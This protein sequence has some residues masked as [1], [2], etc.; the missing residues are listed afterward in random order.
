MIIIRNGDLVMPDGVRQLELAVDKGKIVSIAPAIPVGDADEVIDAKGCYVFPGFID[1]HT[2]FAM[3]NALAVTADDFVSGT[4]AA[5][6]GGT[7]TIINFA[8]PSADG[9]LLEGFQE[10][11]DKAKGHSSCNYKFHMELLRFDDKV[12]AEMKQLKELGVTSYK[13]YMAYAFR[14]WDGELYEAVKAA[15]ELGSLIGAHCEN[16]DLIDARIKELKAAGQLEVENHPLS[17]PA[18]I[19]AEAI[20]RFTSIGRLAG[21]PVH[22]VHVSSAEGLREIELAR[23]RGTAVTCETCPQY[24]LLNEELY[25]LPNFEGAKYVM[26]P[27]LRTKA[28]Q[29][30]LQ[31]AVCKGEFQT[32]AT[33]HCS[34]TW[35]T[36]K[37]QGMKGFTRIPGGIPGVEE[38]GILMYNLFV[39]SG[40][41]SPVELMR[42]VSENPAKLYHMYPAKGILAEGSDGDI[43]ILSREGTHRISAAQQQS[44]SDYNPYEGLEVTGQIRDVLVNGRIAVR[45]GE[46]CE[47]DAGT[48]VR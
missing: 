17:R 44:R 19:E 45:N 23:Q 41:L 40:K 47:T 15:G 27:P 43:T 25:R 10:S 22:V 6:M 31:E 11:M 5:V 16:G 29:K 4:R 35:D 26:S 37:K 38:R 48:F 46:L 12:K 1:A 9:S 36:Q 14:L 39:S 3:A 18:L 2:H 7:T 20:H 42:L 24:L 30:A 8:S 32:L 13:V 28:D 34:Y 33:D 21:C